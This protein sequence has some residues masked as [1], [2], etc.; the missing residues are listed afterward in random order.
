VTRISAP[1]D[2]IAGEVRAAEVVLPC[3]D[4][5][6]TLAF[7]TERLGFRVAAVYPADDPSVAVVTGYGLRVRFE[8]GSGAAAPGVLR[9][10]CREPA[11]LAGGAA[12]LVAPNGTRIQLVDAD[13]PLLVPPLRASF[14]LSRMTGATWV[15]GRAGM[16]YRDLIPGRQGGRYIASH[17]QIPDGGPVPDYVHFH[18]V[19]FQMIYCAS[20]WVR[21]VYEDQGPPFVL[22]A[23]DCVLQPPGIRHRVL[24]SSPGLEVIELSSPAEHQTTADHELA[25]PT[26]AVRAERDFGGQQFVR[27]R[28]AAAKWRPWRLDGFEA[29]DLGIASATGGL[30][31]AHV[32]RPLGNASAQLS[33]HDAE[34]VFTYV[35]RGAVALRCQGEDR[36][37]LAAG[38]SVVVPAGRRHALSDCSD[39]LELLVVTLPAA[40]EI[41]VGPDRDASTGTLVM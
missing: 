4:L 26:P 27:H 22:R 37:E 8:R 40:V 34:L 31:A 39:E 32:A 41:A 7:F 20:G 9:L 13:P 14:A 12:E 11:L 38:D 2:D 36:H 18:G 10:L 33:S 35:L 15:T 16:R 28:A 21:V 19:R 29:R 5:D 23:G 1:A 30:A 17:I 3:T 6:A 24:E 25:L